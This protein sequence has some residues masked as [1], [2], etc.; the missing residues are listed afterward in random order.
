M[1]SFQAWFILSDLSLINR[2]YS[3]SVAF[4]T[5]H[6]TQ[7]P[8]SFKRGLCSAICS[9]YWGMLSTISATR[10]WDTHGINTLGRCSW[11][12]ERTIRDTEDN[13]NGVKN[14]P[15]EEL[16]HT[17]SQEA[18]QYKIKQEIIPTVTQPPELCLFSETNKW[19]QY[20]SL[21][22]KMSVYGNNMGH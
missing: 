4:C 19:H 8:F 1:D 15:G 11:T 7:V 13:Y 17:S 21:G 9:T 12:Q 16:K 3:S 20:M 5:L 18:G 14:I 6:A 2:I 22:R 10:T